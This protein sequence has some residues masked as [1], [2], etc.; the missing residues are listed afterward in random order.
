[1]DFDP[2]EKRLFL[3]GMRILSGLLFFVWIFLVCLAVAGLVPVLAQSGSA[4]RTTAARSVP[5]R[6]IQAQRFLARRGFTASHRNPAAARIQALRSRPKSSS[7]TIPD[8]TPPGSSIWQPLGPIGVLSTS[9]GLVTG[10]VSSLALDPSDATGNTL[11]VGTTGGGVWYSQNA[12]TA[13]AVN[14]VFQPLT[15][16]VA[17]LSVAEDASISIGAVTVQPGG[18]GVILAG[19]GD[20]N[21]AL[22]SYYGAGILRS[23]DGGKTWSLIAETQDWQDGDGG[24]DYGFMGEGFAGFAWS[25]ANPQVVVAA[26]SQAYEGTLVDAGLGQTSYEGLYYSSDAGVT[27]HLA[28][29]TDGNGTDV[30]GISDKFALPDGNA[31]TAVVWNQ[32]RGLFIAAVR[33]HGYYSSPD[34]ITW[35]RLTAQPGTGLTAAL[36]PTNAG[37]TGSPDCPIFRGALAVNPLTGD[38]FAW[39]VDEDNQD[40][41][42]WQDVCGLSSGVCSNGTIAF[43]TQWGTALLQTNTYLGS[44]TIANGDYNLSLAAV[45]SNQDT[46]LLAGA[47][48]LWKCSLAMGCVWRNTTN[49][50]TC[51]SAAVGE[52]QHA[53]AWSATNPLE[54]FDGNDS[55]L[56][57]SE[58]AIGETGSACAASDATHWQNLNG[59]LGSLAEVESLSAVGTSPYTMMVGLGANGTAGVNS[60]TGPTADWPEILGGEGGPVAIGPTNANNWYVNNGAGVSIHSC[61]QGGACTPAEFGAAPAVSNADVGGDGLTMTAPAPFLVDPVD[62]TKLLI[63]TCRLWR[64]PASGS[65]SNGANWTG[66]NAITPMLGDSSECG[67][68]PLIRSMAAMPLAGGGEVVYVGLYGFLNG[69]ATQ[70]GHILTTTMNA[71]GVWSGWTDLTLNPVTNDEYSFNSFDL[72]L[73]SVVIDSHDPSGNTVYVTV[74]AFP[75]ELPEVRLVYRSIDGGAHWAFLTSNLPFAP[76][77]GL[78]IDPVDANTVYVATDVGVFATRQVASCG[79]ATA[80]CWNALGTGLP[81]SP[82]VALG[83]TPPSVSQMCW[84]LPPT[85]EEFGKFL[86]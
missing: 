61:A 76:V 17:A 16:Q 13:N 42:I 11:F 63:G 43:G 8:S 10:R 53:L 82:V 75:D 26:V 70:P 15:D 3:S 81:M 83:A 28:E 20:T 35:T 52:Y 33:F 31:A 34:G 62:P 56:W 19:T 77:N 24:Q 60:T 80:N 22:D 27:W 37:T 32:W 78:A 68:N 72:D 50:I 57:R 71:S 12:A 45:P 69:G 36:C 18:T 58:D 38:T 86:C 9:Y 59:G 54:V 7:A 65:G 46:L 64:G 39:S 73:S 74:A 51:M 79:N 21:D 55:G 4:V 40:Q 85:G 30:Q 29:I 44:A 49:S 67:G 23:A 47:N 41:G 25:T 14:V 48:D 66:A 1:M 5:P 6:V 84:W 2:G